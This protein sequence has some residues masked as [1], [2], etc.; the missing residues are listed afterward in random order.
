MQVSRA[1]TNDENLSLLRMLNPEVLADPYA[2]YRALREYDPV[3]WESVHARVGG[4][5]LP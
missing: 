2:H 4:D 3:H 5:Q 1:E